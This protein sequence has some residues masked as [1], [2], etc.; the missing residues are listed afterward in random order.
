M[1]EFKH[2]A[3]GEINVVG[4]R[5]VE[6]SQNAIVCVGTAP[7]HMVA[8]G[9]K[10]VNVPIVVNN[11]AEAMKLFGYSDDW[12]SYTLCELIHV[13]F[14]KMGVGP[15]VFIN[16]F[17]PAKHKAS[18]VTSV[19][20]TPENGSVVLTD[21]DKIIVDTITVK[22][23]SVTKTAGTDYTVS[24]NFG[25]NT[26]TISEATTG[27]LG[28]SALTITYNA[29]D[30][31]AVTD[32]DVIGT[33]DNLGLNT[34]MYAIRNVE[35][36]TGYIPSF[37]VAPGFS[38][39]PAVHAAM[40]QNSSKIN[41]HWDAFVLADLPIVD[42]QGTAVTL[43]TAATFKAA[44]G[45]N[46]ENERVYYPLVSGTDGN[47][48]H[49]SSLAAANFLSLLIAHDG[50][51]YYTESNT[52]CG[53]I[54][55]LYFGED[56]VGRVID[57]HIINEKLNKYGITSA[58]YVGGRWAIWGASS[59]DYTPDNATQIN[60]AATNLMM[61]YYIS[62]DFQR[63]RA[64][65]VDQPLSPND[66]KQIASEEQTRLDALVSIGA[67]TYGNVVL[68]ASA[69]ANSDVIGDWKFA[70]SVTT[71][72]LAKSLTAVVTWTDDGF[73][74]YYETA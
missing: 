68:N 50:I 66:I 43:D 56:S 9:A 49:L 30:P 18:D 69:D 23:A 4:T 71:T 72:P 52:D 54:S 45:Y 24:T 67:L 42:S 58:A 33:T 21:A 27:A 40:C 32:V 29:A 36:K 46:K 59:A 37:I 6:K 20:K 13:F 34:G 5:V 38:S 16:V 14:K 70:F 39:H 65:Y 19:T 3:Y 47:K 15:A 60:T 22:A 17:D 48:Y 11:E 2:G 28:T 12:G 10:N 57:D 35:Q 41:S 26:V 25:K 61:L 51:P 64:L 1:A 7:V 8:G 44:N 62:N 53:L 74:T 31:S 63:R 73:K 55:N